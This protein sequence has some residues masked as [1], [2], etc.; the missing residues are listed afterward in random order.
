M[1]LHIRARVWRG[2][3]TAPQC[4]REG[5]E[6]R[7]LCLLGRAGH[8]TFPLSNNELACGERHLPRE[9]GDTLH[10]LRRDVGHPRHRLQQLD[11]LRRRTCTNTRRDATTTT[12]TALSS[13]ASEGQGLRRR[14]G[15]LTDHE[16]VLVAPQEVELRQLDE[17]R[18]PLRNSDGS[19]HCKHSAATIEGAAQQRHWTAHADPNA[20]QV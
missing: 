12:V 15:Q 6:E 11:V 3:N 17:H 9:A 5:E 16:V 1:P 13:G 14:V 19:T 20:T 2:R 18:L 7:F 4:E 8:R 10:H